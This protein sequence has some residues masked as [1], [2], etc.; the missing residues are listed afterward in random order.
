[1]TTPVKGWV[2][3]AGEGGVR[4]NPTGTVVGLEKPARPAR[5][6]VARFTSAT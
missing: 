6:P 4:R 3:V 2:W 1:M 5:V